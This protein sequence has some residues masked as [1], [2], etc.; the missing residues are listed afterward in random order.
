MAPRSSAAL[1][2]QCNGGGRGERGAAGRCNFIGANST[3][4]ASSIP[5]SSTKPVNMIHCRSVKYT[6]DQYIL[7]VYSVVRSNRDDG[8]CHLL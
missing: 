8:C 1:R 5:I 3:V 7:L 2:L 4:N 6:C